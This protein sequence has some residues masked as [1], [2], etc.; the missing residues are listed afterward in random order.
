MLSALPK[1]VIF[2]NYSTYSELVR[3]LE[4]NITAYKKDSEKIGITLHMGC[5]RPKLLKHVCLENE[6]ISSEDVE[7]K[8]KP[9]PSSTGLLGEQSRASASSLHRTSGRSSSARTHIWRSLEMSP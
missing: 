4:E 3:I 8:R 1:V 5:Y 6:E 2:I 9:G 7:T